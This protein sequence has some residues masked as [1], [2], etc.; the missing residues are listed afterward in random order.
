MPAVSSSGGI[1]GLKSRQGSNHQLGSSGS[2]AR[3]SRAGPGVSSLN[4]LPNVMNANS[5]AGYSS[6]SPYQSKGA[7]TNLPGVSGAGAL[8]KAGAGSLNTNVFNIPKYTGLSGGIG[9]GIGGGLGGMRSGGLGR[10]SGIGA[11]GGLGSA[12]AGNKQ[13]EDG[14]LGGRHKF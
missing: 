2:Q 4:R 1:G 10:S 9:G 5:G 7:G 6:K 12:G 11:S 8:S 14:E 3:H 13:V